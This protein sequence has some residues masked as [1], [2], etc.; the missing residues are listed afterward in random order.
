M[1]SLTTT[2]ARIPLQHLQSGGFG[3]RGSAAPRV[4]DLRLW[5]G[6]ARCELLKPVGLPQ[7]FRSKQRRHAGNIHFPRGVPSVIGTL[8]PDPEQRFVPE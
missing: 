2:A 3:E 8:H 1:T 7:L 6:R 5:A 4:A